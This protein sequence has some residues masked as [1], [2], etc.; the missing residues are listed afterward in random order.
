MAAAITLAPVAS[1]PGAKSAM[2]HAGAPEP[3][4]G[5]PLAKPP[6]VSSEEEPFASTPTVAPAAPPRAVTVAKTAAPEGTPAWWTNDAVLRAR[7]DSGAAERLG[8]VWIK[9]K[10]YPWW[11]ARTVPAAYLGKV[12]PA[13]KRPSGKDAE[14]CQAYQYFGTLEYQWIPPKCARFPVLT[15]AEGWARGHWAWS[16]RKPLMAG[17]GQACSLLIAPETTPPGFFD[18]VAPPT[19]EPQAKRPEPLSSGQSERDR[20]EKSEKRKEKQAA[21]KAKT[22]AK[23]LKAKAK[24]L[25]L[26]A[27]AEAKARTLERRAE[28]KAKA[29]KLKAEARE[30]K[31]RAKSAATGAVTGGVTRDETRDTAVPPLKPSAKWPGLTSL[32]EYPKTTAFATASAPSET[33][34]A[35]AFKL[36]Y[37][38]RKEGKPPRYTT[39]QRCQWV[40]QRP[41]RPLPRDEVEACLCIPTDAMRAAALEAREAERAAAASRKAAK[42]SAAAALEAAGGSAAAEAADVRSPDVARE[43]KATTP[44]IPRVGCGPECFNRASFTTCDPRV[45]PCGAACGNRPFHLLA[46]PKT[47]TVLTEHRGWGLFLAEPV[48]AGR[49]VVEYTGEIIDDATTEARLWA[50]KARGEDN[51]YLMEVSQAQIIDA[52]HKGNLSRFINSSCHPNCETQKWQDAATGETRVGIFAIRDIAIGEELT[53]DYNFAHFGGEGTTSFSCMCGHPLCRGT[54]DANPERTRNYG[55]RVE[56]KWREGAG[57]P[58]SSGGAAG[59]EKEAEAS[60]YAAT[61]LSY[62]NK[63]EKYEVLYDGGEKEYVRLDGPGAP[64]HR[65]L[66][67]PT[68]KPGEVSAA[69][70]RAE[71]EALLAKGKNSAKGAKSGTGGKKRRRAEGPRRARKPDPRRVK[72][73]EERAAREA[74]AREAAANEAAEAAR[75]APPL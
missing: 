40:C 6:I 31:Q 30:A 12:N 17:V 70:K 75:K 37:E 22:K 3:E 9:N 33:Q 54:L 45:C 62:H 18:Y 7:V 66:T 16:K 61:V 67:A 74:A 11:P 42:A 26:K 44:A 27:K 64:E 21:L 43:Q 63:T 23:A 65:W 35:D 1:V 4:S 68:T 28:A 50:D 58:S 36:P 53:Y 52:R 5:A 47:R 29:L 13:C 57:V 71:A 24:A 56:I 38:V 55:R 34:T 46:S 15:F 19:P 69:V 25:K 14:L 73:R 20:S 72:A 2:A 60:F 39:L 10:G 51:F 49:F 59:L 41:P 32:T 8:L 48:A